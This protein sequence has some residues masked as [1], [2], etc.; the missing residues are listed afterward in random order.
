MLENGSPS[1]FRATILEDNWLPLY[2]AI[3]RSMGWQTGDKL[4]LEVIDGEC[5]ILTKVE[6]APKPKEKPIDSTG[7]RSSSKTSRK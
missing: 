6:D 2:E 7:S 1:K 3:M 4:Q 5:V